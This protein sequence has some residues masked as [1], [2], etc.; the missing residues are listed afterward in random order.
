M[1]SNLVISKVEQRENY[2]PL[3]QS[4]LLKAMC[5]TARDC[6]QMKADFEVQDAKRANAYH[7]D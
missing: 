6:G 3:T 1:D 5:F 2:N 4:R 7:Q